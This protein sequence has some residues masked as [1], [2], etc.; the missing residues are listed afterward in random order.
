MNIRTLAGSF[1]TSCL[2]MLLVLAACSKPLVEPDEDQ[3]A[4]AEQSRA[5][6]R[7]MQIQ[8]TGSRV[9]EKNHER[10]VGAPHPEQYAGAAPMLA[11]P[12]VGSAA[13]AFAPDVQRLPAERLSRENYAHVDENPMHLA[14]ETPVSTFSVDVDTASYANLRRWLNQGSLPPMDAVRIE[15]MLNYFDYDY[16]PPADRE[17]PFRFATTLSS[18]PWNP[19]ALLLRIGLKGFEVARE[20]RPAANLVFLV[21]VSG[22]MHSPDKLDLLKQGLGLLANELGADDRISLVVYAGASGVALYPTPG[23]AKA[24]IRAALSQLQAGG[25]TNG[26]AGIR[27]AYDM[28]QQA[29]IKDGINRVILATDGDFNVGTVNFE[30]LVDLVERRRESGITLTTLGFGTGNYND[31]LMEQLA[32]K[33]NGNY[34]YIDT[35]REAHKTLVEEMSGTLMV[36]A[37]DV[38]AQIEFNPDVVGEYRLIG[39]ENRILARE[40]F[41]NDKV[42]AGDIG[43]GHTV[44]ALYEI[45]LKHNPERRIDPLRYGERGTASPGHVIV[46]SHRTSRELAYLKLR[47]K[48]PAESESRLLETAIREDEQVAFDET[49]ADFR[50]ASAVAAFGQKLRGGKYS[51]DM[52]YAAIGELARGAR[53]DDRH[54]YRGEFLQLVAL[55]DT[56]DAGRRQASR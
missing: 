6:N 33:G 44:T 56:L 42:D 1:M 34:A 8:V 16:T 36:I 39:Y 31:H 19:D 24:T 2:L 21:D 29:F 10:V 14:A 35:I 54:G 48:L 40:D 47:Y 17:Q 4:K 9:A 12:F 41:N 5:E 13:P 26:A 38:K 18:A 37:K 7:L 25:A 28:A 15:E 23:D 27:L 22:S 3:L 43:A 20:E 11:R 30:E 51:G 50:F 55:A 46:E 32:D 52:D 45:V 53:G 49:D